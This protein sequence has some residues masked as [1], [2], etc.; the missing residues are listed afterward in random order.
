MVVGVTVNMAM[1]GT[2]GRSRP[3]TTTVEAS[4]KQCARASLRSI[5]HR[6]LPIAQAIEE[7]ALALAS[8]QIDRGNRA[9]QDVQAAIP[10]EIAW[11]IGGCAC[12]VWS[13]PKG[14]GFL[15]CSR[16]FYVDSHLDG[17]SYS[18]GAC[19]TQ[20]FCRWPWLPFTLK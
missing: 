10:D 1:G 20:Q 12:A 17:C 11:V 4:S 19:L 7:A 15:Q 5:D 9:R 2:H 14:Q 13:S 16:I 8:C 18:D 3:N 6:K